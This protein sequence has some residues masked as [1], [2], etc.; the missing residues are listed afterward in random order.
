MDYTIYFVRDGICRQEVYSDLD[1]P[2]E[3]REL[4]LRHHPGTTIRMIKAFD[5]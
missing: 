2:E 3:A 4:F 5:Y 1:S